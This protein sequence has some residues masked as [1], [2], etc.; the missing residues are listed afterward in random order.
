LC[1][2]NGDCSDETASCNPSGDAFIIQNLSSSNM[3]YIDFR[4]DL[5]LT[6]VLYENSNP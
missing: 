2:E 6:G 1:L 5:C 4:G 3:S